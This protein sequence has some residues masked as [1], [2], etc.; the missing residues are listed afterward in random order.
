[1]SQAACVPTRRL[2]CFG[3]LSGQRDA[4]DAN[5]QA[6]YEDASHVRVLSHTPTGHANSLNRPPD[7]R[8]TNTGWLLAEPAQQLEEVVEAHPA[9]AVI[10]EVRQVARVACPL[11]EGAGEAE[12]VPQ[13]HVTVAVTIAEEA[14]ERVGA[15]TPPHARAGT[16]EGL[17]GE[18]V[19]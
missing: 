7:S 9:V 15:I 6:S 13:I 2:G 1:R 17:P 4:P 12:Q 19:N 3:L 16:V 14:E 10:V 5:E 18:V 11:A 8:E